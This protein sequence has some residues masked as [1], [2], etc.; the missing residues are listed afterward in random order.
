[1]V[2]LGI[3]SIVGYLFVYTEMDGV[4]SMVGRFLGSFFSR[5]VVCIRFIVSSSWV[6]VVVWKRKRGILL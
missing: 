1:M 3:Y 2:F 6:I 4:A 5:R